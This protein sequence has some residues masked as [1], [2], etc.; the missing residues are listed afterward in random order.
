MHSTLETPGRKSHLIGDIEVLRAIAV[1]VT[2]F[3]HQSVLTF[4]R[5]ESIDS[6]FDF[7]FGVDIFFVVS[8]FV[9]A[10]SLLPTLAM[11]KNRQDYW[12]NVV[13]FWIRRMWR[14]WPTA[15]LWTALIVIAAVFARSQA[16]GKPLPDLQ[17]AIAILLHVFNLHRVDVDAIQGTGILSPYWSLSLEEQ[18]Y[19]L[20]PFL[21]FIVPRERLISVLAV[22]V[23]AQIFL[24]RWALNNNLSGLLW[25]IRSDGLMLGVVIALTLEKRWIRGLLEPL[26]LAKS[27]LAKCLSVVLPLFLMS[28]LS[29]GHVVTFGTGLIAI[30]SGWLVWVAS[31]DM[32]YI[33]AEG[34][35]KRILVWIGLRSYAIYVIHCPAFLITQSIWAHLSPAGTNLGDGQHLWQLSITAAVLIVVLS[36]LNF[37]LIEA[38]LRRKGAAIAKRLSQEPRPQLAAVQ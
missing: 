2:V 4:H 5:I 33:I 1:L 18:F 10:R 26:F 34:W 28:A 32:N 13:A 6:Y 24:T 7:W 36:E 14:I 15:W 35:L 38:P 22:L 29:A 9:I 23:G 8:G 37:R 27:R 12:R 17:D 20:L 3:Q 31:Y 16:W 30:L 11:A 19:L 21:L 25:S